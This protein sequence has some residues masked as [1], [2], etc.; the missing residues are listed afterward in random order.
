ME[1]IVYL[2]NLNMGGDVNSPRV[3]TNFILSLTI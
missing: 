2:T 1:T 3:A